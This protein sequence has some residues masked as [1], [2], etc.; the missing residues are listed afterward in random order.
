MY[1]YEG[2]GCIYWHMVSKVLLAIQENVF[3]AVDGQAPSA[4]VESLGDA[5]Y[6][7]RG[8]LSS[9]KTP[10]EYGAIPTDPYSH[11]PMHVGARQPGMTGQVKEEILTR[12]GELGVR[13]R[14]GR[15]YFQPLL[16]RRRELCD[17]PDEF[18]FFDLAVR[19]MNCAKL[20]AA[21]EREA[22]S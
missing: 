4:V 20:A 8:G 21:S 11:T 3:R 5:Y 15:L 1:G 14:D 2:L 7:V 9:N 16:L 10:A 19:R 12:Q 17:G 18:R 6:L 22:L 13:I